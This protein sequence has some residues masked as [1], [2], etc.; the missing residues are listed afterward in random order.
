MNNE[1]DRGL[2]F[3]N[4]MM[5]GIRKKFYRI[6]TDADGSPRLFFEN[7]GGSLRL[8]STV[9]ISDE[10]N[11]YPDCYARDHKSSLVL[12][13]YQAKGLEDVRILLNAKSGTIAT[14]LTA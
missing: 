7:A 10:L 2:F 8:R 9:E 11:K 12:Q 5:D 3:S 4:E 6:D 14:N 1:S 13:Q